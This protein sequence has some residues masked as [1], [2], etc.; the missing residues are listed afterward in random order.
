MLCNC[1]CRQKFPVDLQHFLEE[2]PGSI[3]WQMIRRVVKESLKGK[4]S[5]FGQCG[6]DD[7]FLIG[8]VLVDE[9]SDPCGERASSHWGH[10]VTAET[11]VRFHNSMQRHVGNLPNVFQIDVGD[12]VAK[13]EKGFDHA[14]TFL[15]R[16]FKDE[17]N[18]AIY[19]ITCHLL[20]NCPAFNTP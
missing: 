10:V 3:N 5:V 1:H 15:A 7:E 4:V 20:G 2:F 11:C 14:N 8:T 6:F 17:W 18:N 9:R 19:Q 12:Q 16:W 13:P